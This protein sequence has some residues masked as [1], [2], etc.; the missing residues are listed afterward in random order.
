MS[1]PQFDLS[2]II[3]TSIFIY[4]FLFLFYFFIRKTIGTYIKNLYHISEKE[5]INIEEDNLLIKK[6]EELLNKEIISMTKDLKDLHE[7]D[8]DRI[9]QNYNNHIYQSNEE[10]KKIF[11]QKEIEFIK[12]LEIKYKKIDIKKIL[13]N[14]KYECIKK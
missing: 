5:I 1:L 3:S 8:K 12:D 6:E 7:K 13:T 4:I 2:N 11:H 9:Q 14:I 10:L